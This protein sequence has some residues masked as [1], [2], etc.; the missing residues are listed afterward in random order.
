MI[1]CSGSRQGCSWSDARVDTVLSVDFFHYISPRL[2][3]S[4]LLENSLSANISRITLISVYYSS[5]L[6]RVFKRLS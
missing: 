1:L 3:T 6:A 5:M 4:L 2:G